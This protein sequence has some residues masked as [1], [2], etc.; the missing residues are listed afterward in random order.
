MNI[1]NRCLNHKNNILSMA[2]FLEIEY[3]FTYKMRCFKKKYSLFLGNL[4]VKMLLCT[5]FFPVLTENRNR[6]FPKEPCLSSA[7]PFSCFPLRSHKLLAVPDGL[8]LPICPE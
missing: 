1:L 4:K 5:S 3:I 7:V 2:N 8:H 6:K